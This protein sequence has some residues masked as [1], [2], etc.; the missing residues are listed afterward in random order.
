MNINMTLLIVLVVI[1]LACMIFVW[2]RFK[3]VPETSKVLLIKCRKGDVKIAKT[4]AFVWPIINSYAVISLTPRVI[5]V[6]SGEAN[7]ADAATFG[8]GEYSVP[9]RI[10]DGSYCKDSIR[11]DIGVAFQLVISIANLPTIA[12]KFDIEMLNDVNKLANYFA[13]RFA[14][15]VKTATRKHD[16]LDLMND[17]KLYRDDV[18]T[19]I[20]KEMDGFLLGDVLISEIRQ[21]SVEKLNKDDILDV[22]GLQKIKDI[23]STRNVA[24]KKITEDN[25][26]L[27]K[28]EEVKG[29]QARLQL[30]RSLQTETISNEREINNHRI[31]QKT[32]EVETAEQERLKQEK[33]RIETDKEIEINRQT[34]EREVEIASVNNKQMVGIK[35]QE[36]EKEI[37]LARLAT[38]LETDR[39]ELENKVSLADKTKDYEIKNAEITEVRKTNAVQE[40][41]T[42]DIRAFKEAER[43]KKVALTDAESVAMAEQSK[44]TI[45]AETEQKTATISAQTKTAIADAD[46]LVTEKEVQARR[47]KAQ[48]TQDE[49]AAP[50]IGRAKAKVEEAIALEKYGTAEAEV[51]KNLLLAEAEGKTKL[52]EA[53]GQLQ[54]DTREHELK[55]KEMDN[56]KEVQL[57]TVDANKEVGL[58]EAKARAAALSKA[59]ISIVGDGSTLEKM[60]QGKSKGLAFDQ[61]LKGS[62]LLTQVA[63]PYINGDKDAVEDLAVLLQNFSSEDLKNMSM[64]QFLAD[65]KAKSFINNLLN[66]KNK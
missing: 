36:T 41:E 2:T 44:K 32:L 53:M 12:E 21:T 5:L 50:G 65:P 51:S 7:K 25:Q 29:Q 28:T 1:F 47:L 42:K 33:I 64:A 10:G 13:P 60:V 62:K 8:Q 35:E 55:L 11:V 57:R 17:R 15:A 63:E 14:E 30:E 24:I 49:E 18:K 19:S 26:T 56:A 61:T 40:E 45:A 37:G 16:Y 48:V 27:Y 43:K 46:Y 39:V 22:E 34:T 59:E 4:G 38:K 23:T 3:L 52:Y 54:D 31:Q 66:S 20:E 6:H 9:I 58:E